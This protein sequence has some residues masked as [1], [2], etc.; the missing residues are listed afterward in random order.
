MNRGETLREKRREKGSTQAEAAKALGV[1]LRSYVSYEKGKEPRDKMFWARAAKL[2][3]CDVEDFGVTISE[4]DA[5]DSYFQTSQRANVQKAALLATGSTLL[6]FAVGGPP[7]AVISLSLFIASYGAGMYVG[8]R[9]ALRDAECG[10]DEALQEMIEKHERFIRAAE[11]PIYAALIRKGIAPS[12]VTPP[13]DKTVPWPDEVLEVESGSI[14]SWWLCY[15]EGKVD[16]KDPHA[17]ISNKVRASSLLARFWDFAP[18]PTRK[19]SIVVED[20]SLYDTLIDQNGGSYRG[21][22]STILVD[23]LDARLLREDYLATYEEGAD[24]STLMRIVD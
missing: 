21:N 24:E 18:D 4:D 7:M 10:S 5:Y 1:S 6:S 3:D 16:P 8:F 14:K 20:E 15:E 19:A 13:E 12:P 11:G 22:L 9:D 23:T 2:F 17:A